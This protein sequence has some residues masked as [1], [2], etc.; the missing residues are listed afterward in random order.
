MSVGAVG[1]ASA[2]CP[3]ASAMWTMSV[4]LLGNARPGSDRGYPTEM[5]ALASSATIT[6]DVPARLDRLPFGRWHWRILVG[7]GTV[8]ILDGLEVTIVGNVAGRIAQPGSGL[9]MTAAAI[10]G[11]GATIYVLGACSGALFFGWLTD[12]LGRKRLFM[13][14]LATYL[15]GTA[16]TG[17]AFSP[18]WFFVFRF[19]TGF[20]IGG[21]YAA[22]NSA[23]DELIP[24][25]RRGQVDVAVNG[26]YWAGAIGGSLLSLVALNE[27]ILPGDVGWRVCFGLGVVLGLSILLVRRKVPESPRW[28]LMRGRAQEAEQIVCDAERETR[29]GGDALPEPGGP[30]T[31]RR[32]QPIGIPTV[33]R[34]LAAR[35]PRRT[36]L[37]FSLFVGQ[38]FLYNAI[39]FGY[40]NILIKLFGVAPG[41]TGYYFAVI[42]AGNLVGPLVLAGLFDSVGRKPMVAGLHVLPGV[43]LLITALL[44]KEGVLTA[45]TMTACWC[46]VFFFASAG[47][48][49]SYLTVSE[50]FPM[51]VRALAIGVFY[52]AGTGVGGAI[53]PLVF[54]ALT[55]AGDPARV[56]LAYAIG[57]VLIIASGVVAFFLAVPAERRSLE[58]VAQPLAA[59]AGDD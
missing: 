57:S 54:A 10:S 31:I 18:A 53:G 58:S 36:V 59:V 39:T 7:L 30:I 49:S 35:Y 56:A 27:R 13:I 22:I 12:R 6:S 5:A 19:I 48:S 26:S 34:T 4:I 23:I 14:T 21:E 43:L 45:A 28:L 15:L 51:E 41:H 44:T 20:G 25:S 38:A 37:G 2:F 40:A 8:W 17:L 46:V 33:V 24:A 47:A 55:K 32:R 52:A 11:F 29:G 3:G 42:A 50:I 16:M 1:R 9:Q